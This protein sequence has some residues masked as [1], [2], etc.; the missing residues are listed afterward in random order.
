MLRRLVCLCV[1]LGRTF[2]GP[3][4]IDENYVKGQHILQTIGFSV[5]LSWVAAPLTRFDGDPCTCHLP[6][7]A[8]TTE[9][10]HRQ[11]KRQDA[12]ARLRLLTG[13]FVDC[14]SNIRRS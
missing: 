3:K 2:S 7:S 13:P 1:Q 10:S 12:N 6:A 14:C 5:R 9:R 8:A 11:L 4:H